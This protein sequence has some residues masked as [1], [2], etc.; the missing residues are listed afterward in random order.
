[1]KATIPV[2]NI[3]VEAEEAVKTFNKMGF[4]M[5]KL[6]ILGKGY[7]TEEQPVGFYTKVDRIRTWAVLMHFGEESGAIFTPDF[8]NK[9]FF[10][11]RTT[12]DCHALWVQL[13][14]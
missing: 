12:L 11:L 14:L 5:E 8:D 1:M 9:K 3:H 7:Q 13:S 2:Y 6:S 4:D 10:S